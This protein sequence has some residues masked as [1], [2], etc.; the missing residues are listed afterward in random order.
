MTLKPP[1]LARSLPF[2]GPGTNLQGVFPS[3]VDSGEESNLFSAKNA[4]GRTPFLLIEITLPSAEGAMVFMSESGQAD[5]PA[6]NCEKGTK[7][8]NAGTLSQG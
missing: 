3:S 1:R 6:G 5:T 8:G 7:T 2:L 4:L